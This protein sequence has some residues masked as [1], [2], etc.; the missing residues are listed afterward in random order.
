MA[1]I[2]VNN[3]GELGVITDVKPHE[4]PLNAWSS[5]LNM[6]FRDG[7]AEKFFGD[8]TLTPGTVAPYFLLPVPLPVDY[9]W[10]YAGLNKVYAFDGST[11][12]NITRQTL[13]VDVDYAATELLN[14]TG[15]LLNGV[16]IINNGVDLPQIWLPTTLGTKLAALTNWDAAWTCSA[17]R[18]Y[19]SFLVALDVNKSGTRYPQMVKWS[20]P[21]DTGGIPVSWDETDPT[22]DA[23]EYLLAET[24][25]YAVDCVPL[26]DV[27]VVYKE[28]SI[29]LMQYIGGVFIFRFSALSK[30]LGLLSRRCAVEFTPGRHAAFCVGDIIQHDGQQVKSIVD[31]KMRRWLFNNIDGTNYPTSFVVNYASLSEVWF[32][33]P[34]TGNTIPNRALVW[35]WVSN[36]TTLRQL[37]DVAH[38]AAGIL[39]S[40]STTWDAA[41]GTW[42]SYAGVWETRSYNPSTL[43]LVQARP[44]ASLLTQA[45]TTNQLTGSAMAVSLERTGIA[46]PVVADR[47]PDFSSYKFCSAIWPRIEGTDGGQVMVSVGTQQQ[48]DGAVTWEPP[49]QYTI[50]STN[51]IDCRVSGRLLAVKFESTAD[52]D[53]RLHGYEL[54][55]QAGGRF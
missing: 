16:P 22:K 34:T 35:N 42:D 46:V 29:Y 23:G 31:A 47:P 48:I 8:A 20:H 41:V 37:T 49:V 51:K 54:N 38:I 40:G 15:G 36:T 12:T 55:V 25:G 27:N 11:H 14:W 17:M 45:E 18:P 28:D 1:M 50:G 33:F 26:R 13:G 32:C 2:P 24:S 39:S 3:V 7:Y 53:W 30:H 52:I 44:L 9:Y 6:R 10:L 43:S 4:L 19:K 5:A 21:A